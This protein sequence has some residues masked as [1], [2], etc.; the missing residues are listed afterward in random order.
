MKKVW[1]VISTLALANILGL[2]AFITWLKVS[3]RLDGDRLRKIREMLSITITSE[4]DGS[5]KAQADAAEAAA[6][7]A[8][9][10]KM[11]QPPK[12]SGAK[13]GEQNASRDAKLQEL[14]RLQQEIKVL[15]DELL[16]RE[17]T[18][19]RKRAEID[20]ATERLES[21][22]TRWQKTIGTEQFKQALAILET[23]KPKDAKAVLKALLNNEPVPPAL[24]TP[25]DP[26]NP[27]PLAKAKPAEQVINYLAAMDEDVRSKIMTEFIKDDAKL[28]SELL[29]QLR[30]KGVE[31]ATPRAASAQ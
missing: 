16:T 7:A 1:M 4:R 24:A 9:D 11:S 14:L 28:A 23:Q 8:E 5:A 13:I 3:D 19:A 22:R 25:T 26:N 27:A 2:A 15:R 30:T 18:L 6:K 21:A 31:L 12:D 17:A 20:A 29:E 10:E